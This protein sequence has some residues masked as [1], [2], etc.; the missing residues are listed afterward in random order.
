MKST[1][2]ISDKIVFPKNAVTQTMACIGK[3]GAGKTYLAGVIA[4]GMLD[5]GAQI[6]ILDPVGNWWGLRVNADGKSKGKTIYVIGGEHGD[7]PIFPS[8]GAKIARVLAEKNIPA[9]IDISG[10]RQNERKHFAAEFAEEFFHLKK[11][12][13]SA[14]HLFVEEAQ[15]FIPQR[16]GPDESR[17]LGAFENIVRLGR[18]YGIGATLITQR[19]QSVNKEVLS[20]VECLCVLQ[21][22]GAHERKA[23]E[24]WVQES[25]ADRKVIGQLPG[26]TQGEGYVWS[27]SWLRVFERVRFAKKTTFDA[28]STPEV[29]AIEK[30]ATLA[31]IDVEA[32]KMDLKEIV[33][34]ATADDPKVLHKRIAELEKQLNT[35]PP[36]KTERIDME[37]LYVAQKA[38]IQQIIDNIV[39]PEIQK[40]FGTLL[41]RNITSMQDF[42]SGAE[43]ALKTLD[44]PKG[45]KLGFLTKDAKKAIAGSIIDMNNPP[46][47]WGGAARISEPAKEY[48]VPNPTNVEQSTD[49][50]KPEQRVLNAIAWMES[51]G[52]SQPEQPAVAFLAGYS[53]TS[54]SYLNTKAKLRA[55]GLVTYLAGNLIELTDAGRIAAEFPYTPANTQELHSRVMAQLPNPEQRLLAPLLKAYPKGMQNA[56]LAREAG[57][58]VSSSAFANPKGRLR[59]L[60]LVD[61]PEVGWT[62][63]KKL[64]FPEKK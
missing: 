42:I 52:V 28:S 35:P 51:I 36:V 46:G 19:P 2:N 24:E 37:K 57:Y 56:D 49:R 14:V 20:Q 11:T 61:Y 58:S 4:E 12:Q 22:N 18:N 1:I 29:G 26:L 59:T 47:E 53:F 64:L 3:K 7:L 60:G 30:F 23:L 54:S 43:I 31:S 32:L 8:S 5:M 21:V 34:K 25:G 27:P 39:K 50:S 33:D 41:T 16:C 63:A 40:A 38:E 17:M 6:V 48:R 62:I 10:F 15:L 44:D 9:V 55:N 13:R 45:W